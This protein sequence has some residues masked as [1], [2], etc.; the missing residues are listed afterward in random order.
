MKT[1]KQKF[2]T[3]AQNQNMSSNKYKFNPETLE[4]EYKGISKKRKMLVSG[5]S[6]FIG[7]F[8]IFLI[9][10]IVFSFI[11]EARNKREVENEYNVLQEQYQALLERK[12]K[13]DQYL[14]ELIDKDKA[15]YQAVFKT[16]PDNSMFDI[17][18]PYLKF[19]GKDM[20]T[21]HR[22]NKTRIEKNNEI[23]HN[24]KGRV[25]KI[26]AALKDIAPDELRSIPAIQPIYNEDL[27]F[28][29]Y[30][31]GNKIDHVY[32]SLVFHP[33][34][35][36]AAPE[37]TKVFATADGKVVKAGQVRGYGNRIII[38]HG[39]GYKTLYAHLDKIFMYQGRKVKRGDKIGTVGL[40]GKSIIPHLHYEVI[41]NKKQINPVN[42]FFL[43]LSPDQYFEISSK[44]SKSGLSLD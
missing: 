32:K 30:G 35:D 42:Y 20:K 4:F 27:E 10:F 16:E 25:D 2:Y 13:N 3:F 28:P 6:V 29:V 39:N 43:D 11:Y 23:L 19:S 40:S 8:F 14:K 31:F 38:D 21:I 41:Y 37:G 1:F 18:N 34:I 24:Q 7:S 5:L 44:A 26:I 36:I 15:I 33:G 22:E 9:I 17:K 12:S